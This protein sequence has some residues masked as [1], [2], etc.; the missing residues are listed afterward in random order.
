MK[1]DCKTGAGGGGGIG[2]GVNAAESLAL[3]GTNC[4]TDIFFFGY[5]LTKPMVS[6]KIYGCLVY[7]K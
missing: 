7:R 4:R 2:G 1:D 6:R 3:H 5:T